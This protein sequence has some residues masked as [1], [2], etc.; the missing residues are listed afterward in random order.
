MIQYKIMKPDEIR[1]LVI[2]DN[3]NWVN[4]TRQILRHLGYANV[5]TSANAEE[6]RATFK[7]FDPHLAVVDIMLPE[8]E[9]GF[10]LIKEMRDADPCMHIIAVSALESSDYKSFGIRAGA[11]DYIA[12]TAT[13]TELSDRLERHLKRIPLD[14]AE[15]VV[16]WRNISLDRMSGIVRCEKS[17][18]KSVTFPV[19]GYEKRILGFLMEN[20]GEAFTS[21]E[22]HEMFWGKEE[23]RSTNVVML[24]VRAIRGG[25]RSACAE[26]CRAATRLLYTSESVTSA[27]KEKCCAA[28]VLLLCSI[29]AF[30]AQ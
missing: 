24:R 18:G 29:C 22:L 16:R 12:K 9:D 4:K 10:D 3:P 21:R 13:I 25:L 14:M 17:K 6:A 30:T 2:E 1:I 20:Q 19:D 27:A 8:D 15:P 28:V 11:D 7:E 5:R 26:M 23:L